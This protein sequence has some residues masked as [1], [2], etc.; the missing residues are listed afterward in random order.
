MTPQTVN[1]VNLPLQ[2]ALNFPAAILQPP[3]FDAKPTR[4]TTTAPSAP[5]SATRSATAS[6]TRAPS[7]TPR[8]GSPTGG[9]QEDFAHFKAAGEALAAQFDAYQPL[10]DLASTAS[11]RSART[12]PTSPVCRRLRRLPALAAA[13]SRTPVKDGLTGDQ[14]FFISFGQSWRSKMREAAL[15]SRSLPTA[16]RPTS[17]APTRCATSTPGTT[18][19]GAAP[20][21]LYL[22]PKDRVRVW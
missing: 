12:S 1:A 19:F 6:T 13:A 16:T 20:Q 15:R 8:A 22:A 3:F 7:S 14:R 11:R 9:R 18:L 5:S 10:P 4:R 21:K 2:N 17:T